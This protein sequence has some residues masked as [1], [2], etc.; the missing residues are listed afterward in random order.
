MPASPSTQD[1]RE[2]RVAVIGADTEGPLEAMLQTVPPRSG[3]AL[4]A[5]CRTVAPSTDALQASSALPVMVVAGRIRLEPDRV[6][7]VPPDCEAVFQRGELVAIQVGAPQAPLDKLLRSLAAE[8]GSRGSCALLEGLGDDG[9]VGIKFLREAGGLSIAQALEP[10][11]PQAAAASGAAD[12]VLPLPAIAERL[13]AFGR[14]SGDGQSDGALAAEDPGRQNAE[15]VTDTLQDILTQVRIRSGHDFSSYKRATLYRRVSRRIQISQCSS[16]GGYLHYLRD[17]PEEVGYL[18]RDFLISVTNFFRDREAFDAVASTVIP[19][20]FE[21]KGREDQVRVWV[22]GCATGEEAYSIAMLLCEYAAVLRN[23]PLLQIFATDIDEDSLAEARMGRYPATI[24]ADVSPERLERFFTQDGDHFR[25]SGAL[26]EIVLFSPHNVL[27][28]PPF[29]RI[30]LISCRNLMIYLNRDAQDRVLGTFHFALRLDGFLFLGTSESAENTAMFASADAKHRLMVRRPATALSVGDAVRPSARWAPA[31]PVVSTP[32]PVE[33]TGVGQLH[34]QLVERLGPPSVLVNDDLEVLHLSERAGRLMQ[35]SG[36]EPTRHLLRMVHSGLRNDLRIA[37]YVAR[38]SRT[39]S[40]TRVV[41][42]V[43]GDT[44]RAIEVRVRKVDQPELASGALLVMFDELDA[45]PVVDRAP[46]APAVLAPALETLVR[47]LEDELRRTR[48]QLRATIEQYE[49]SVEELK[50]SNEELQAINEELRSATEELET[51]KEELQ[52]VN[53]ELTTVNH[54]LKHKVDEISHANSDLQNLMISTDIGVVFLDRE[55]NIKRFTPRA[56]DL[57]NVIPSDIGRP[58]AH[59]THRLEADDLTQLAASVLQS[60]R[61]VEREIRSRDGRRY[62][63]RLLPYRSLE[64][65]I[66]GVVATFIDVT[67]LRDATDARLR[68][69]AALLASEERLRFALRTAPML[70]VNFDDQLQATWGYVLGEEIAAR[71]RAAG[72]LAGLFAPGHAERFTAISRQVLRDGATQ[73]AELDVMVRNELRTYD[74][75]IERNELGISAVGFD[76]TAS[77]HAQA[78]LVDADR[79]KDEFLATLSHE[80]RNPLTP[81]KVAIDV[82]KLAPDDPVQLERTRGIMER[83]VIQLTQLVD[84][85]L[86]LSRIAQGKIQLEY[87]QLDPAQVVDAAV[88]ATR[89]LFQQRRQQLTVDVPRTSLRVTGDRARL[90]QVLTNLLNNAAKYT[91]AGGQIALSMAVDPQHDKL[92]IR[93]RD[94]GDGIAADLLPRIFDIFVQSRRGSGPPQSG[95][96][97]GL[98]LVQRLIKLHGGAVSAW[99]DGPGRGSEFTIE[100]P[101]KPGPAGA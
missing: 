76:I 23:P 78:A 8:Y 21:G 25:I 6:F 88:E 20:L 18:L 38:Q 77:K 17:H 11:E 82:L 43:D 39:G 34:H 85:L 1:P 90:T 15:G 91:P 12:L 28:D 9:K 29:S 74:F 3:L 61:M 5:L 75:R 101:I 63:A 67:D 48:E 53:E 46:P 54:E 96:G 50:A 32:R 73:R 97:I 49:T 10:D 7:V 87:D 94:D 81:L 65:R 100:L 35:V 22:A 30:D 59:L 89:P 86:D 27:R 62:L 79:R 31:V 72:Q 83:Q 64:D 57:F 42:F 44:E 92:A 55:F 14:S 60:L 2:L 37:I 4:V 66:G 45:A 16:I 93:I 98:N 26:R 70:V 71:D 47:E 84:D 19:K 58:L 41:R 56:Q 51:S 36:G 24:A 13:A 33:R 40:D 52:S 69:E 99:S 68:S 95:L 80:L